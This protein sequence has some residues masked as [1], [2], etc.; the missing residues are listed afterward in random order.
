[1]ASIGTGGKGLDL[2]E[3]LRAYFLQAGYF[4]VRGVPY[5]LD[6][7]DVTDIDLWLYERPGASTR[8][9]IIVDIKNKKS[10]KAAERIIWTKGLQSALGVDGAIVATTDK[11]ASTRKLS[12]TL[13]I[14]LLDGDAVSKLTRSHSLKQAG[15][16]TSEEFDGAVKRVD[17]SRRT[18]E[19]RQALSEARGSLLSGLGVLSTNKT[20]G[21]AGFFENPSSSSTSRFGTSPSCA[22]IALFCFVIGSDQP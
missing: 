3:M 8:R 22:S 12:K 18:T 5:R 2:E 4:V 6:E 16:L 10:P 1:M 7:E 20:L 15:R 19:W 17:E 9:R 21:V 14:T 11:R 13:S